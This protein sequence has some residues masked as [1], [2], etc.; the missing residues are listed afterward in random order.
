MENTVKEAKFADKKIPVLICA[1]VLISGITF[2]AGLVVPLIG[3]FWLKTAV[4]ILFNLLN[5][6][7]AFAAMEMTGMNLE[8]NFKDPKQ[9]IIGIAVAAVLSLG[10]A[11][12]PAML[13][14]SLVGGHQDFSAGMLIFYFFYYTLVIGPVEELIFREYIQGTLTGMI[15]KNKWAGVIAASAVFGLWHWINGSIV[16]VIFTFGIGL[17]FGFVRYLCK[18]VRLPGISFCHGLYDFLNHVVRML[19][20]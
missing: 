7:V 12:I 20:L 6:V 18:P 1:L 15:P 2:A 14:T 4:N 5:A 10:I 3:I 11:F 9:Y 17:V 13:G 16:Q 8:K 19:I